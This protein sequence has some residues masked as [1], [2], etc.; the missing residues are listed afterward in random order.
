MIRN[1][2]LTRFQMKLISWL[3]STVPIISLIY[4]LFYLANKKSLLVGI[5]PFNNFIE[6]S[7]SSFL[8]YWLGF[9]V[10]FYFYFLLTKSRLQ[11][12]LKPVTPR[13]DQ[14]TKI[15]HECLQEVEDFK[16]WIEGWFKIDDRKT[17][18]DQIHKSNFT[19]WYLF[20]FYFTFHLIIF[21]F[22]I[23]ILLLLF[24]LG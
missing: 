6:S 8:H 4:Y 9:E 21:F 14:R 17:T 24:S 12:L 16:A 10:L 5:F 18:F 23:F 22:L 19:E 20:T 2:S 15:L 7:S 1:N 3:C 13:K 11:K